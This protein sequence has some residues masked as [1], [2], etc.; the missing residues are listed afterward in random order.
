MCCCCFCWKQKEFSHNKPQ[1]VDQFTKW[2]PSVAQSPVNKDEDQDPIPSLIKLYADNPA[3]MAELQSCRINPN[4]QSKQRRDLEFFIPQIC[5]FYLQGYYS[6]PDELVN[7]I[8][9]AA[10]EFHFSH[11]VLFFF[12]ATLLEKLNPERQ[13]QQKKMIDKVVDAVLQQVVKI[14]ERMFLATSEAIERTI[15]EYGL[16]QFYPHIA[17]KNEPKLHAKVMSKLQQ[18]LNNV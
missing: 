7:F 18:R 15:Q 3:A 1:F 5:S 14:P 12:S 2:M 4:M 13:A 11:R 6:K 9:Q 10:G 17:M 16:G 8:L